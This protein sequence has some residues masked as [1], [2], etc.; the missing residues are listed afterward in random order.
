MT[1]R[2]E[3]ALLAV[4]VILAPRLSL[5]HGGHGDPSWY[6]SLT[7]YVVEP[8]HLP[9]TLALAVLVLVAVAG[10]RRNRSVE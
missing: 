7:H 5:A 9:V 6:G 3:S 8:E 2:V 1:R 4:A 10:R